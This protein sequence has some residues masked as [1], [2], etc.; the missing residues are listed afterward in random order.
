MLTVAQ[1]AAVVASATLA[2]LPAQ[3]LADAEMTMR[4]AMDPAW[5]GEEPH[6]RHEVD[7]CGLTPEALVALDQALWAEM[8]AREDAR[9][10]MLDAGGAFVEAGSFDWPIAA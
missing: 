2:A 4:F 1:I 3:T 10:A 8:A 5:L 9:H 7:P 6:L